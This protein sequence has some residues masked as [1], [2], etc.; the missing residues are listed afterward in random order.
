MTTHDDARPGE[1]ALGR[2][3]AR[4]SEL[5][6]RIETQAAASRQRHGVLMT[7]VV[8]MALI[9]SFGLSQM[10]ALADSLDVDTVAFLGRVEAQNRLPDGRLALQEALEEQAPEIVAAALRSALDSVPVARGMMIQHLNQQLDGIHTEFEDQTVRLV[11]ETVRTARPTIEA[12]YPHTSMQDQ[13]LLVARAA[14]QSVSEGFRAALTE[15]YP[16]YAS[17][18]RQMA[19]HMERLAVTPLDQLSDRERN[20]RDMIETM[21]QLSVRAER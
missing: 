6:A 1:V 21:L 10:V 19:V 5:N 15:L 20:Q 16:S 12:A 9:T 14:A 13:K 7:V 11:G 3:L 2:A 8:L 18:M 4:I 17:R